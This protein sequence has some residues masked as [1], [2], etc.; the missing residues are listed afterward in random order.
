MIRHGNK[1]GARHVFEKTLGNIKRYQIS[2]YHTASK[3][4]KAEIELDPRKIFHKTVE[5]CTPVLELT[6]VKR[7]G[8]V[9]S[10]IIQALLEFLIQQ[11]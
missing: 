10:V 9:Y 5:N 4:K 2:K 3:D 8:Q 6:S 1:Q 11:C 7:G